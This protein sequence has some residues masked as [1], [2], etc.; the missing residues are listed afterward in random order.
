[1]DF[2]YSPRLA[3]LRESAVDLTRRIAVY[4]DECEADN[5]LSPQSRAALR[6]TVLA[7]GLQAMNAPVEWGGA[8]LSWIEQVTVEEQ[9]GTLT[10]GLWAAVWRPT[11]AALIAST[12]EQRERYL[13]PENRGERFGARA[14]TEPDAGSDPR[15]IAT[16]A[17]RSP[18]GYRITGEKWFVT[19]GDLADYLIVLAVVQPDGAP[20]MFLVD[21]DAPGVRLVDTP[22]YTH[23]FAYEHPHFAF[24]GVEVGHDAVLGAVGDGLALVQATFFEER[25][26]VAAH[27]VGAAER[28]LRLASDWARERVQGGKPIIK[29]Q[30]IQAMLADSATD[31]A[32]N[33]ML[34]Y[35]TAWEIDRGGD[36]KT[37]N[38]KVAMAKVSATEAAGR[39]V[40][41][42]V[43]IFGGRGYMRNN[44]VERLYRDVRVDRIWMGTSE[45]QRLMIA[46]EIDKRG[47]PG[48]L[49]FPT[50]SGP[51]GAAEPSG[52]NDTDKTNETLVEG[53]VR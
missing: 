35:R 5:G 23:N 10:N 12:P 9:L 13:I 30:L 27:A 40:D 37:L 39:V 38:A 28:A 21:K 14:V 47:L 20:T 32:V 29:H 44:P 22:H 4:E 41:R 49:H 48:L 18:D 45:V 24:D 7:S 3:Q 51:G 43:Q 11:A 19:L 8:G 46:N 1:M 50:A 33:R 36:P 6:R 15:R 52:T 42:A 17:E 25:V 2:S 31:I 34:V 53:A 16:V 26:L